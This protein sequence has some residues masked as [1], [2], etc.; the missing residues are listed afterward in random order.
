V[1]FKPS[2]LTNFKGF[3][4]ESAHISEMG[5]DSL[6]ILV[7]LTA[8]Y[9]ISV[10]TEA[11]VKALGLLGAD[12]HQLLAYG[13]QFVQLSIRDPEVRMNGYHSIFRRHGHNFT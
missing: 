9:V 4:Q 6:R 3:V 12:C 10:E 8:M 7:R 5:E 13:F 1:N 11:I 2:D